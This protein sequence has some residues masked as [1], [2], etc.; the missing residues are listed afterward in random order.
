MFAGLAVV[1]KL[2]ARAVVV[3]GR[4]VERLIVAEQE[5][6]EQVAGAR[7]AVEPARLGQRQSVQNFAHLTAKLKA[8]FGL[9]LSEDLMSLPNIP[10]T[11][12][13][14]PSYCF[15]PKR[16]RLSAWIRVQMRF[17]LWTYRTS[18]NL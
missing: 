6:A 14:F 1:G 4:V 3:D 16:P 17:L 5:A 10:H 9:R 12:S 7:E 11:C 8:V 18:C 13:K 2:A 15:R